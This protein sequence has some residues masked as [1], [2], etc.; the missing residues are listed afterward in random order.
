MLTAGGVSSKGIWLV[1][2]SEAFSVA[3]KYK[4]RNIA[5]EVRDIKASTPIY[6]VLLEIFVAA[7]SS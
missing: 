1:S 6:S 2:H 4:E 7:Q 3:S 5:G